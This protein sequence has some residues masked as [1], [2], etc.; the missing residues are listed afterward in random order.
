MA[1]ARACSGDVMYLSVNPCY[2]LRAHACVEPPAASWACGRDC[3][4]DRSILGSTERIDGRRR[5][6][7]PSAPSITAAAATP[8]FASASELEASGHPGDGS[9]CA[10]A[11][12]QRRAGRALRGAARPGARERA[13]GADVPLRLEKLLQAPE[14]PKMLELAGRPVWHARLSP[15]SPGPTCVSNISVTSSLSPGWSVSARVFI[16]GTSS[17]PGLALNQARQKRKTGFSLGA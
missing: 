15:C 7:R 2:G 16:V 9:A 1:R 5:E 8:L 10:S 12:A 3:A 6:A 17:K 11:L 13:W 4:R 14:V